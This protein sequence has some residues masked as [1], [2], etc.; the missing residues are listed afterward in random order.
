MPWKNYAECNEPLRP[1]EPFT[2]MRRPGCSHHRTNLC[3]LASGVL[4]EEERTSLEHHLSTCDVCQNYYHELKR[5]TVPLAEWE[6]AYSQIEPDHEM[7][8]RW[9]N[10]F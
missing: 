10:D 3:L 5:F 4:A 1:M 7:R 2:S 9:A 6:Q 8:A